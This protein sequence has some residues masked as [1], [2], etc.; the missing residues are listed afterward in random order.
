[1][2]MSV[3]SLGLFE[4]KMYLK[5]ILYKY[6]P[7]LDYK[8]LKFTFIKN[9]SKFPGKYKPFLQVYIYILTIMVCS[10]LKR[11]VAYFF[12]KFWFEHVNFFFG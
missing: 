1:M 9:L 3:Q 4:K 12:F 11:I 6:S 10:F 2:Y 7:K 5:S 8:I